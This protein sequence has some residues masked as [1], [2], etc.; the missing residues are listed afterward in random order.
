M[1]VIELIPEN[2]WQTPELLLKRTGN[3]INIKTNRLPEFN[4]G[5]TDTRIIVR[6]M[7]IYFEITHTNTEN[8]EKLKDRIT[9]DLP[10]FMY[11]DTSMRHGSEHATFINETD[12]AE[13]TTDLIFC[14]IK[15][16]E[17]SEIAALIKSD[18]MGRTAETTTTFALL[19]RVQEHEEFGLEDGDLILEDKGLKL[20]HIP[21][22]PGRITGKFRVFYEDTLI[23]INGLDETDNFSDLE[24]LQPNT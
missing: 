22:Y 8:R 12:E 15:E 19:E 9:A 24:H 21:P 4:V 17:E 23:E 13:W 11:Y 7:S 5:F 6:D 2:V 18:S 3:A 10:I 14:K 20:E 1:P 16:V